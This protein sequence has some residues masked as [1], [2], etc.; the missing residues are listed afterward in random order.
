MHGVNDASGH[1]VP[2]VV[3]SLCSTEV[4]NAPL[5]AENPVGVDNTHSIQPPLRSGR[6]SWDCERAA[7][8]GILGLVESSVESSDE[9]QQSEH[10]TQTSVCVR[11]NE[12]P[13]EQEEAPEMM[14]TGK[15]VPHTVPSGV[16]SSDSQLLS[17]VNL[18][19]NESTQVASMEH[20]DDN[21]WNC[22]SN[23][24]LPSERGNECIIGRTELSLAAC[25][26]ARGSSTLDSS[27][28][29]QQQS[30]QSHSSSSSNSQRQN[31]R[32]T[33]LDVRSQFDDLSV[34]TRVDGKNNFLCCNNDN[35]R[36]ARA[37]LGGE[38]R[39]FL[40][41]SRSQPPPAR[42]TATDSQDAIA[43]HQTIT[44]TPGAGNVDN[45][46]AAS[47]RAPTYSVGSGQAPE[48]CNFS[49]SKRTAWEHAV[50]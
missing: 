41:R 50:H 48:T 28:A 20:G 22:R 23:N 37:Q 4:S 33:E 27:T 25:G 30:S 45:Y 24:L 29:R 16:R 35:E 7:I 19:V 1:F 9:R 10:E 34:C 2:R 11:R 38:T 14:V 5:V 44:C 49:Q 39:H 13:Q 15:T 36:P 32:D 17:C 8:V 26:G 6:G 18:R 46:A 43:N 21:S 12:G 47:R 3:G 40:G 42:G 31:L